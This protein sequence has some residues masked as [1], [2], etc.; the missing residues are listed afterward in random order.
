MKLKLL[1]SLFVLLAVAVFQLQAAEEAKA[2]PAEA[3]PSAVKAALMAV[4]EKVQAK[5]Q[6]GQVTEAAL[7]DELKAL[8]ALL[9]AH[10]TEKTDDVAQ[11]LV[12]KSVIY[13]ELI[14]D[15]DKAAGFFKQLKAEF[16]ESAQ[17]KDVDEVLKMIEIQ[18]AA[19]RAQEA[20][21]VGAVFP[22]FAE[23]DLAGNPLSVG[24][25]KGSV[26]LVDFWATWCGPCVEDMPQVIA[27]YEKYHA[28]GLEIIGV[29]LDKDEAALK[30]FIEKN[31]MTW[32]QFFDGKFWEN[33][34]AGQYGVTSIPF[35]VLI[36]GDG[37]IV[38]TNLRGA[39]LD[40]ALAT[41]L[42]Q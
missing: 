9:A 19:A 36:N 42:G 16:P 15:T 7:A 37:K 32:P 21:K 6:A 26:V 11:V 40:A 24:K 34:L 38:G 20:L 33:K 8:D 12:M 29:S 2:A 18:Q 4:I 14:G 41:L 5:A 28:R 13:L 35:T 1:G 25:F 17:A 31:K 10:K 27:L 23:K 30:A 3:A 22:D 39:K